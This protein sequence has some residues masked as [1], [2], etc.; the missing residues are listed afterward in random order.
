MAHTLQDRYSSMLDAKLRASLVR[1]K[2]KQGLIPCFFVFKRKKSERLRVLP[3]SKRA[4]V[5]FRPF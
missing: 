1:G 3:K 5:I 2:V 4:G